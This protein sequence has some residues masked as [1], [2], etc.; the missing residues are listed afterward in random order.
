MNRLILLFTIFALFGCSTLPDEKTKNI[1]II[2]SYESEGCEY[3][4][5]VGA[6]DTFSPTVQAERDS[7]ILKMKKEALKINANAI[8]IENISSDLSGSS[9]QARAYKC[10]DPFSLIPEYPF[11]TKEELELFKQS[12]KRGDPQSQ[13]LY[14]SAILPENNAEGLNWITI[15]AKQDYVKA[16]GYLGLLY[17]HGEYVERNLFKA[18]KWFERAA[19]NGDGNIQGSLGFAYLNGEG[20]PTNE[21]QAYVWMSMSSTQGNTLIKSTLKRLKA[22][23]SEQQIIIAQDL[24]AKCWESKFKDCD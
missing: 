5:I 8:F 14:G 19:E 1:R 9:G 24:A 6:F 2:D 21:I 15:S 10:P 16:Q 22:I 3:Q 17:Y 13:Y 20:V 4:S 18:F 7:V 12:A 23:M 11:F